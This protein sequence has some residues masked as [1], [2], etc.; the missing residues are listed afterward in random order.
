MQTTK[1]PKSTSPA[2]PI[3]HDDWSDAIVTPGGGVEPTIKALRRAR[4][5]NKKPTKEQIAIR[6][7]PDILEAFRAS[8]SGWQSRLNAALR[9][10]LAA[11]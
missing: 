9:E 11:H 2:A 4:G 3:T 6:L 5:K 10:W 7:D 8:G 1:K